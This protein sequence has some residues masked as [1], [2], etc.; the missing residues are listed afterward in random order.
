MKSIAA[1]MRY[2][3]ISPRTYNIW[4]IPIEKVSSRNA[5]RVLVAMTIMFIF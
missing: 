1:V 3:Q 5:S 2:G 4:F